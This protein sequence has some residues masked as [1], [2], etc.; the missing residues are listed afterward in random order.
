M[1]AMTDEHIRV[2]AYHLWEADGRPDGRDQEFWQRAE[3][4]L[5]TADDGVLKPAPRR[6]SRAK[7]AAAPQA[8]RRK[9]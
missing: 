3:Q 4:S 7:P 2:R 1:T 8:K 9:A 5:T 6:S